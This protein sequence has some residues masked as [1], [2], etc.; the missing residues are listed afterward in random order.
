MQLDFLFLC[1][2]LFVAFVLKP[3]TCHL[4]EYTHLHNNHNI[5]ITVPLRH[6][7]CLIFCVSPLNKGLWLPRGEKND[8][9]I[10]L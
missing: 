6:P 10:N 8:V 3:L 7:R 2:S 9:P 1:R 5:Y 4:G